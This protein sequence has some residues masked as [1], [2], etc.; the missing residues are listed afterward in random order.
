MLP[1]GFL[2]WLAIKVHIK[3]RSHFLHKR[4]PSPNNPRSLADI[5]PHWHIFCTPIC[6]LV[7][8]LTQHK[9]HHQSSPQP[10][11][12]PG[13]CTHSCKA[14]WSL[15]TWRGLLAIPTKAMISRNSS[16]PASHSCCT[17]SPP[18]TFNGQIHFKVFF[19]QL[20]SLVEC[21]FHWIKS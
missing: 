21:H 8:V 18:E 20:I 14:F 3:L 16:S 19:S 17:S 12:S 13:F 6:L 1:F 11:D 5:R 10:D 4:P 15:L 9:T 2:W 7:W